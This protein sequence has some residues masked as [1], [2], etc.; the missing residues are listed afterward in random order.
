MIQ[1]NKLEIFRGLLKE[2]GRRFK[3]TPSNYLLSNFGWL[4]IKRKINEV[5]QYLPKNARVLDVGCG[6]GYNTKL[7]KLSRPDLKIIGIEPHNKKHWWGLLKENN[8]EFKKGNALKLDFK[9]KVFDVVVSFGVM[10]HIEECYE[11]YYHKKEFKNEDI[12]FMKEMYRVLKPNGINIISLLPNKYSISEF[13]A[14]I[15]QVSGHPHKYTTKTIK[16]ILKIS[17]FKI[18]KLKREY[19]IPSQIFLLNKWSNNWFDKYYKVWDKIDLI[20]NKT[21]LNRA[22]Q[23]YMVVCKKR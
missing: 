7:L 18:I 23:S 3:E 12:Q 20:L 22:S 19:I 11:R 10:E 2:S 5:I 14:S 21:L 15:A 9:D 13:I 16:K 4:R 17:N 8:C 1:S 6:I